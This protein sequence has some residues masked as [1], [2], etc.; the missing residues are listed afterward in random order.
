MCRPGVGR[1]HATRNVQK[2][3][4][5]TRL[6]RLLGCQRLTIES[7]ARMAHRSSKS[8]QRLTAFPDKYIRFLPC[9]GPERGQ[10][11]GRYIVAN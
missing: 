1:A 3:L 7:A 11:V 6:E 5:G 2:T 4:P 9:Q 8:S 10:R